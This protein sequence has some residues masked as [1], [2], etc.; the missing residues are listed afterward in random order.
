MVMPIQSIEQ[1]NNAG[2]FERVV[3]AS[4]RN[5]FKLHD[6]VQ[7]LLT[8]WPAQ[9]CDNLTTLRDRLHVLID[10]YRQL[11]EGEQLRQEALKSC[12]MLTR[13]VCRVA[14]W[15]FSRFFG[16]VITLTDCNQK[17]E[18][19]VRGPSDFGIKLG[20][21]AIEGKKYQ[22][23]AMPLMGI[24]YGDNKLI[25]N[26]GHEQ[27]SFVVVNDSQ[28]VAS[29]SICRLYKKPGKSGVFESRATSDM[30]ERYLEVQWIKDET[31]ID[32]TRAAMRVITQVVM[33]IF[34]RDKD[35]RLDL[36][37]GHDNGFVLV[38][39]GFNFVNQDQKTEDI[40]KQ[41]IA[42]GIDRPEYPEYRDVGGFTMQILKRSA[43]V[44]H[45]THFY[46]K[47]QHQVETPVA[48]MG[49]WRSEWKGQGKDTWESIIS[50]SPILDGQGP[51]LPEFWNHDPLQTQG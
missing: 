35:L 27:T 22:V 47:D 13:L 50:S 48:V 16:P 11:N 24:A 38:Q 45:V 21:T 5:H 34:Q 39:A 43:V 8:D 23:H 41:L 7:K 15:I 30:T 32:K 44:P 12:F 36:T 33:E 10:S 20:E 40:K 28:T 17:V 37:S 6:K 29:L 1:F 26:W 4:G 51:V 19:L 31:R 14:N 18:R 46:T 2:F 3:F 49:S 9:P 42:S 25:E